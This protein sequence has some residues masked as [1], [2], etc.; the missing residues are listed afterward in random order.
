[1]NSRRDPEWTN[2]VRPIIRARLEAGL[3]PATPPLHQWAGHGLEKPCDACDSLI[4]SD[5]TEF[6][7][8]FA[9]GGALRFHVGCHLVWE[10]ER[11]ARASE[12]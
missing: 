5:D 12:T 1:M 7:V 6:E 9:H 11:T 4:E 2:R 8:D 3:L 10:Q